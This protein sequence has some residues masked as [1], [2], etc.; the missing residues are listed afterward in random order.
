MTINE[1]L[2]KRAQAWDA[3]KKFLDEKSVNGTMTAEDGAQYDRMEQEITD[4][5]N[6]IERQKRAEQ[7]ENAM[8]EPVRREMKTKPGNKADKATS[9]RGTEAYNEAYWEYMRLGNVGMSP[10][11]RNSLKVGTDSDGGYLVPEEF[12]KRLLEAL[13]E[14]NI[15][16]QFAHKITTSGDRKIPM[17]LSRGTAQWIEEEEEYPESDVE[18]GQ[19]SLSAYKLATLMKISEELMQDSAFNM[20]AFIA[21]EFGRRIGA[22]EEEAFFT[23]DGAGKPTGILAETGAQTG[24]TAA[25]AD[26][27]TSDEVIDLYYSLRVPYRRKAVFITHDS[28]MKALRKLQDGNKQYIWQPALTAGTPDMLMGRPVYT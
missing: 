1:L 5:T 18:F 11:L 25:A 10:E 16:R 19:T 20:S 12:E 27:I 13:D 9:P 3:A 21:N 28:A 7:M 15:F 24:V 4:L 22:A 6:Q 2:N 26:K 17:V 14:G 8:N 23:G